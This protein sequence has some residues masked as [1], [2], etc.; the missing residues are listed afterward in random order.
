MTVDVTARNSSPSDDKHMS[1][2]NNAEAMP[3]LGVDGN[4]TV[5]IFD[6]SKMGESYDCHGN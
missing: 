6:G 2:L 5:D 3:A 1:Q 4:A